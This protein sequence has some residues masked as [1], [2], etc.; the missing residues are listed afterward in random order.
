M[1]KISA[2]AKAVKLLMLDVDGVMTDGGIIYGGDGL[3]LKR[4]DVK[5]GH[6]IKLLMGAG[7]DVAI[8]TARSSPAVERRARELGITLLYQGQRDKL[9]AFE[10]ILSK[11]GLSAKE[12]AYIGDDIVD[13]PVLRRAGLAIAVADAVAEVKRAADHVTKRP[14]GQGAVRETAELILRAK[15]DWNTIIKTYLN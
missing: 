6:G 4:F 2:R 14:G 3:E 12:T 7:V 1:K 15:G 10:D 8:V 13:L 11:T 9:F 5:D